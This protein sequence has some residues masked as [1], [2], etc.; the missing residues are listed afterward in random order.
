[1]RCDAAACTNGCRFPDFEK[2][3][4][5]IQVKVPEIDTQL[6]HQIAH[7]LQRLRTLELRKVPGVADRS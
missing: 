3:T 6:A 7:T 2:E 1:M 4:A 5:I